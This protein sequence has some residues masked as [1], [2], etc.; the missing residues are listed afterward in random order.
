MPNYERENLL[1]ANEG[2]IAFLQNDGERV[3]F[4]LLASGTLRRGQT[5]K[6]YGRLQCAL[7]G[8]LISGLSGFHRVLFA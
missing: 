6:K 2:P 1:A 8:V 7:R 3:K 5:S 4:D